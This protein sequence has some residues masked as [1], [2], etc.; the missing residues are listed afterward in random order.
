MAIDLYEGDLP[1]GIDLGKIIA[2][3]TETMGLRPKRDRLC[4]VQL[5]SGDGNAPV[6]YT[7]LTLPTKA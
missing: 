4:L 7:H 3:D 2:I 1:N 6:S 5:S